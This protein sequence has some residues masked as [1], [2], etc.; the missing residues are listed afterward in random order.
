MH[1]AACGAENEAGRKFCLECG[2]ALALICPACS[3]PNT[4]GAKFCGECGNA[5]TGVEITAPAVAPAAERR[6]VSVLFADLVGFTTISESR[7]SEEVRE[8]LTAYFDRCKRLIERYGG[9]VEKFIGD[10]V[11]AVW[12]T[13]VAKEDDA[14]RAVRAALDLVAAV[15]ELDPALRARAGVLTGEAAVTLGAE[16]QGMVAGDLVNTASRIQAE[17]EPGTVL[18]GEATKRATE[19]AIAYDDAGTH[20]LKGKAEPMQLFRALRV[21]AGRAGALRSSSLEPPFVGRD[22]ELRLIKELFHATADE[23]RA[24][25]VSV[26]GVAGV[27][28]SRISWEFEK[29]QD[30]LA[31]EGWWHRGRCLSYGEGVAYWALAEMVRM[32]CGITEDEEVASASAKLRATLEQH[33]TDT[34]ER[35]WVEPRLAHLLGLEEGVSGDQE[36]LFSAW[37]VLFERLAE[38]DPVVLVF[39]DMQWAD[40]GLVDFL[41]YLLDWSRNHPIFV[42]SLARPELSEKHPSWGAGKRAVT[43]LYLEPLPRPAMETLLAGLVPGLPEELRNQILERAEGVPLY[44]VETVRMLLD[45]GLLAHDGTAFQPTGPIETL[46]VPETLHALVAA[47]LDGLAAEERRLVQGASVLGKTFTKQGIAALT[48]LSDEELDALLAS[49]LRKEV[50]SIQA[51]P[52]SPERGQYSFLQ[53]IV[54]HV[55]YETLSKRERKDKHL[56]A[57]RY[58]A[59]LW[60]AAEED[61]IVEVVAA[62][63]LDAWRAAPE[64]D[65]AEEIKGTAREMLVR[66]AERA[67]SLGAT[68]EAQRAFERAIELAEDAAVEADLHER[69]GLEAWAGARADDAIAHFEAAISA[70]ESASA[71]HAAAR[72]S[73][74]RA[75]IM[76]ERGKLADAIESLESSFEVLREDDPDE[77]LATLAAQLGRFSFFAGDFDGALE[78][79]EIALD[80]AEALLL[81]EVFSQALNTKAVMLASRSR[82]QESIM[83]VRHALQIAL[84]A[85]KPSAA[86]R[87]YNN[88]ADILV[89]TDRYEEADQLIAEGIAYARRVG[90]R[91]WE[92]TLLAQTYAPFALGKWDSVI[93]HAAGLIDQPLADARLGLSAM[94]TAA[95]PIYVQ[96]GEMEA[97]E[98]FVNRLEDL[99]L[100]ADAQERAAY[101]SGKSLVLLARGNATE[102]LAVAEQGLDMRSLLGIGA[103]YMKELFVVAAGAAFELK[104]HTRVEDVLSIVESLPPGR[105]SQAFQAQASRFRA[106]LAAERGEADEAERLFKRAAGLLREI[107]APFNLAVTQLEHAELLVAQGRATEAE[108]LL[109][110]AREV[111][112]GLKAQPWLERC[113]A[114]IAGGDRVHAEAT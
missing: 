2:S 21:I 9:T 76:W 98:D 53:D 40:A 87:A 4:P 36:N 22:R 80:L 111:F 16:G 11:M 62:H 79:T 88:V 108:P 57:A 28:K 90:N 106:R 66:A 12:G 99:E 103:E 32:R 93:E 67:S 65:D 55:A 6:L 60:G 71:A 37:R 86:L 75:E 85:D 3:S 39:E 104:D 29:Y 10:A 18:V 30:G 26:V 50:L 48:D 94:I 77:A 52:R 114:V 56:A 112:E 19:A 38:V 89:Q 47:R 7:D 70:F 45:R 1:C 5:F 102:A 13:P 92:R 25:L 96:R 35:A 61:E 109:A 43:S 14:E 97:A 73:A 78:R 82:R 27:G 24:Q 83:L 46:E 69:A 42:L 49:L 105:S 41:D 59:T 63:Y 34:E 95:V 113:D 74:R 64:A 58:L 31:E 20:D 51:D 101:A 81:P 23:R 68:A 8:L 110:E 17:A 72:V 54:K 100:G 84:E 44:A 33:V 91:Q 15:A 107:A